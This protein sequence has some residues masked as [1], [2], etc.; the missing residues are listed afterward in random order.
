MIIKDYNN[1]INHTEIKNNITIEKTIS[2]SFIKNKINKINEMSDSNLN[3]INKIFKVQNN[4]LLELKQKHFI[5]KNELIKKYKEIKNYKNICFKLMYYIK[6]ILF[7][8]NNNKK[9]L[10]IQNQIIKENNILRKLFFNKPV[11]IDSKYYNNHVKYMSDINERKIFYNTF[12]KFK[13]KNNSEQTSDCGRMNTFE[14]NDNNKKRNKSFERIS[15]KY[16]TNPNSNN[17]Y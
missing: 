10:I 9:F 12:N 16:K 15:D 13:E 17:I 3:I 11:N 7:K 14:N 8:N 2:F 5:L 1:N 4:I 6:D